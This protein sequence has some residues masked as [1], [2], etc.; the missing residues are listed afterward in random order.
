MY[1]IAA[2]TKDDG[3]CRSTDGEVSIAKISNHSS[4]LLM[5]KLELELELELEFQLPPCCVT[6]GP[7]LR[8]LLFC[9]CAGYSHVSANGIVPNDAVRRYMTIT[10]ASTEQQT[11]QT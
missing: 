4:H 7:R 3:N 6:L 10:S 8:H 9:A 5:A 1:I 11:I 2:C